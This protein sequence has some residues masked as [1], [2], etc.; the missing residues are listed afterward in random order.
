MSHEPCAL[1]LVGA[2]M[3]S[4]EFMISHLGSWERVNP[5]IADDVS[6]VQTAYSDGKVLRLNGHYVRPALTTYGGTPVCAWHLSEEI[7]RRRLCR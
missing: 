4:S 6:R 3:A 2:D 5:S 1:C 7:G